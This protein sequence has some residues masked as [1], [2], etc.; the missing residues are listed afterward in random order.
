VSLLVTAAE[1]NVQL[2]L[3]GEA[4]PHVMSADRIDDMSVVSFRAS[5][6][7]VFFAGDVAQAD[8]MTLAKAV[9]EPLYRELVGV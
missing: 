1:R 8:L 4:L 5:G 7:M 9:A 3:P 2:I 6:H